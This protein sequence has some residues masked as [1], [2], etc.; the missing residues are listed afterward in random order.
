[1]TKNHILYGMI[2]FILGLLSCIIALSPPYLSHAYDHIWASCHQP[3]SLFA[4]L[5]FLFC[6]PGILLGVIGVKKNQKKALPILGLVFNL[7]TLFFLSL[8]TYLLSPL[9]ECLY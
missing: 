6:I 3:W 1:M 4:L 7:P 9:S 2:P 5:P 8:V